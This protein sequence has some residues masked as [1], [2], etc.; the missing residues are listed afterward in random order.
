MTSL[1]GGLH[2]GSVEQLLA[3]WNEVFAADPEA[4]PFTS[5]AWAKAWLRHWGGGLEPW[6]VTVRD[7][8]G[9]LVG[10]APLVRARR[11]P[12]RILLGLGSGV[13]NYWEILAPVE[14]RAEVQRTVAEHL[15][16]TRARW[17]ILNVDRLPHDSST[18]EA[19]SAAGLL[20]RRRTSIRAPW[21]PLPASWDEYLAGLSSNRRSK[22]RRYLRP[23]DDGEVQIA[24]VD[25]PDEIARTVAK[26][27][28]LRKAWWASRDREIDP[29]H[30]SERFRAFVTDVVQ[31]LVAAK[32]ALVRQFLK[33]GEVIGVAIDFV[34][35]GR[36]YY[37]LNG[38]DPRYQGLRLG[39]AVVASGIR[40]GIERGLG[41]F[42]FMIG[43]EAYKYEYGAEDRELKWVVVSNPRIRSRAA[44]GASAIKDRIRQPGDEIAVGRG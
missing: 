18:P 33:E 34:D 35:P 24:H 7:E 9:G 36:I 19:L 14:R 30:A 38:F 1:A 23:I 3:E 43:A 29:E 25:E 32:L 2:E 37:W 10:L 4:T 12:L 22:I 15:H 17:D 40:D 31:D 41:G 26:W 42:D 44:S 21:L 8:Q 28:D 20:V 13:G 6:I 11:G 39:H 16:L 27:Q 5:P